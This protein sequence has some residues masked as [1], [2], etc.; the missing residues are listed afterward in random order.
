MIMAISIYFRM[1]DSSRR[2]LT[3]LAHRGNSSRLLPCVQKRC[4]FCMCTHTYTTSGLVVM[5][6]GD[7]SG[8]KRG[9]HGVS[10]TNHDLHTI[11]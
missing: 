4:V 6:V 9:G 2:P 1:S 5:A 7:G 3:S 10:L 11:T 8:L